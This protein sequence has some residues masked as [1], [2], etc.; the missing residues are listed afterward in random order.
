MLQLML[1]LM[2]HRYY[3]VAVYSVVV[4]NSVIELT[5]LTS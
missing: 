3:L 5:S 1:Q 4:V 2:L